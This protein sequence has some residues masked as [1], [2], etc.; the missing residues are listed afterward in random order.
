[1]KTL[2]VLCAAGAA[3][4]MSSVASAGLAFSFADPV[5]GRQVTHT[6]NGAGPGVGLLQYDRSANLVFLVDGSEEPTPFTAVFNSVRLEMN[7]TLGAA[8]TIGG[9]TTAPVAG[10]FILRDVSDESPRVI[11][12]GD[13]LG[14][15]FVRVA[16]TNSIQFSDQTGF[17]YT[18][19]PALQELLAPGRT[20]VDPQEAV[21]TLTDLVALGGGSVFSEGGVIRSFQANASFSGTSSV[22]PTP[23]AVAL[24]GLGV[25]AASRRRR[26]K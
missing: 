1:M 21:F 12:R 18:A 2:L 22:V 23:G 26:T 17:G 3:A 16:G 6:A 20:I 11:L 24:A 15:A 25:L 9:V 8:T 5:P 4:S 13:A 10:S 14:G 7:L 19:G